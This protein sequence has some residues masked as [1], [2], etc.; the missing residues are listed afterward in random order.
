MAAS[1]TRARWPPPTATGHASASTSCTFAVAAAIVLIGA[2]GVVIVAQP[3]AR[4]P[5]AWS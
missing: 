4:R 1:S 5:D 2:V 3:G